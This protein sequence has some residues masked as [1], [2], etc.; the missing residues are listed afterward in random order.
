MLRNQRPLL[1]ALSIFSGTCAH[2]PQSAPR[3]AEAR[4]SAAIA[5]AE[6]E[7]DMADDGDPTLVTD[8]STSVPDGVKDL[9]KRADREPV[10]RTRSSAQTDVTTGSSAKAQRDKPAKLADAPRT[11]PSKTSEACP[12]QPVSR[13]TAVT[14]ELGTA[15]NGWAISSMTSTVLGLAGADI[16]MSA[17]GPPGS[18]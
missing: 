16:A 4:T 18:V 9:V 13:S 8:D 17:G 12:G 15:R 14:A 5:T 1:F 11:T 2:Q 6:G 10:S 7:G 3:S